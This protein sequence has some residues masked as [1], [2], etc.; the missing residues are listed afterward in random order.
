MVLTDKPLAASKPCDGPIDVIHL[1]SVNTTSWQKHSECLATC[2]AHVLLVQETRLSA[3]GQIIMNRLILQPAI[4]GSTLLGGRLW[5]L[6]G[7]V[8]IA[9]PSPPLI[10]AFTVVSA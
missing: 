2:G 8:A 9:N 3:R 5:R 1:L 6:S 7:H 10:L 4:R